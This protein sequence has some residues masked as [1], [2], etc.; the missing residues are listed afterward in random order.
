MLD[1]LFMHFLFVTM[2]TMDAFVSKYEVK[3]YK[4]SIIP[5]KGGWGGWGVVAVQWGTSTI[6][7]L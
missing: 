5:A 6:V 1:S 7:C 4:N 2:M 3:L